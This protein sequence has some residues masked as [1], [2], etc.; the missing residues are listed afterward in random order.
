MARRLDEVEKN[1]RLSPTPNSERSLRRQID[2][3][4][5]KNRQLREQLDSA[6]HQLTLSST[7]LADLRDEMET[8]RRDARANEVELRVRLEESVERERLLE[9]RLE[10]AAVREKLLRQEVRQ[11]VQDERT[12]MTGLATDGVLTS[13][14]GDQTGACVRVVVSLMINETF[15]SVFFATTAFSAL[16]LLVGRQEERSILPVKLEMWANAQRDGRPAEYRWRPLFKAAQSLA[17]AHY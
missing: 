1:L 8:Q 12:Q 6:A 11:A 16:T 4:T 3:L 9:A 15:V 14:L 7:E 17:D 10:Q 13:T 2:D 5:D